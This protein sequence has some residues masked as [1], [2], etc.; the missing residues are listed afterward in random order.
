VAS[1]TDFERTFSQLLQEGKKDEAKSHLLSCSTSKNK[2]TG[3]V[4]YP[5]LEG[6]TRMSR[7]RAIVLLEGQTSQIEQEAMAPKYLR[8]TSPNLLAV[9][10]EQV[11]SHKAK[12][13]PAKKAGKKK[14]AGP[15]GINGAAKPAPKAKAA[16]TS[17]QEEEEQEEEETVEDTQPKKRGRPRGA[18]DKKPRK[19]RGISAKQ[20]EAPP[21]DEQDAAEDEEEA[22][23][24]SEPTPEEKKPQMAAQEPPQADPSK[25]MD[26]IEQINI[27]V[28]ALGTQMGKFKGQELNVTQE[29]A[30]QE[31][32][33]RGLAKNQQVIYEQLGFLVSGVQV[34]ASELFGKSPD[35]FHQQVIE[36]MDEEAEKAK[37]L[38]PN[39]VQ[40]EDK[41]EDAANSGDK[42]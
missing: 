35:E 23:D 1:P 27:N 42:S 18:K 28:N 40:D 12:G 38:L 13:Q 17:E 22:K 21:E 4:T 36:Y 39:T 5:D 32:F 34:M 33:M 6:L 9:L 14:K 10:T 15:R 26:M 29:L 7:S 11:E 31:K 3:V 37:K 2:E 19:R 16:D 8:M 20:E 30:D 25:L 24:D 41:E